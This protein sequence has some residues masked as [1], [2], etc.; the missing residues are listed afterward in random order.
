MKAEHYLELC[1]EYRV[2]VKSQSARVCFQALRYEDNDNICV[3]KGPTEEP[4]RVSN[5]N[6]LRVVSMI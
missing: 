1:S 4:R 5:E 6:L 3:V 2:G